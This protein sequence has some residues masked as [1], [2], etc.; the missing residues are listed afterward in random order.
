MSRRSDPFQ[1]RDWRGRFDH[2]EEP[3]RKHRSVNIRLTPAEYAEVGEA[4]RVAGLSISEYMR[5]RTLGIPVMSAVDQEMIRML[6]KLGGLQKAWFNELKIHPE[7]TAA[8]LQ[9]MAAAVRTIRGFAERRGGAGEG[10]P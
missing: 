10:E 4:A 9:E 1:P 7:Q 2:V 5:R 8:I 3:A 6:S